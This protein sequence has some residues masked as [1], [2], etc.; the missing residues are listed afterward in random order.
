MAEAEAYYGEAVKELKGRSGAEDAKQ[1]ADQEIFYFLTTTWF[2]RPK[3]KLYMGQVNISDAVIKEIGNG[4][5]FDHALKKCSA[6]KQLEGQYLSLEQMLTINPYSIANFKD[7]NLEAS[8]YSFEWNDAMVLA[9]VKK[10]K[11][12]KE[13]PK[14]VTPGQLGTAVW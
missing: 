6:V 11:L 9:C 4:Y 2:G 10:F 14:T 12:P 8:R 7:Y 13:Q 5:A 1:A 3:E